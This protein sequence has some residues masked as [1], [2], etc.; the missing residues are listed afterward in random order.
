MASSKYSEKL[1]D[2]ICKYIME[3][4]SIREIERKK[5]MPCMKTIFN[6]LN[7]EK[8]SYFL[9]QYTR[10][11]EVQTEGFAEEIIEI[12][13]DSTN[14]YIERKKTDGT[15]YEEL[16]SEHI[17]RSRLRIESRKWLMGKLKPKKYGDKVQHTGAD[18][19]GPVETST[20][21]VFKPVGKNS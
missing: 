19:E 20:T 18:G 3:G 11:K 14:D 15:T 13:D 4:L 5:D 12:A 8:K 1:V 16:N 9:Q 21:F 7:D 17:Q 2:Q 6:W 10:A